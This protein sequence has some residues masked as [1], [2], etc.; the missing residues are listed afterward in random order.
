M[1]LLVAVDSGAGFAPATLADAWNADSEASAAG[2]ARVEAA[3]ARDFFPGMVELVV[4]PLAVNLA[5]S[6]SYDLLKGLVARLRREQEDAAALEVTDAPAG[7]GDV[8]IVVR[9]GSASR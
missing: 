1:R 7:D 9:V 2:T 8:V 4:I 5:S 3:G 6:I